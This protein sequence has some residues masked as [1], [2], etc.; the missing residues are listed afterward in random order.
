MFHPVFAT[1]SGPGP[2][3]IEFGIA[4]G[5]TQVTFHG[6]MEYHACEGLKHAKSSKGRSIIRLPEEEL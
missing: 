1:S 5:T 3:V 2:A 6:T 4:F